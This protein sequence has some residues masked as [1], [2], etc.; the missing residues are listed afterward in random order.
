MPSNQKALQFSR[1]I[2]RLLKNNLLT[3]FDPRFHSNAH[4]VV[5][6]FTA[7]TPISVMPLKL[8]PR[9]VIP[10][11]VQVPSVSLAAFGSCTK[12]REEV[13]VAP[14]KM[15]LEGTTRGFPRD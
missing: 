15:T 7:N 10:P 4:A 1:W 9:K 3:L 6:G 8:D 13:E 2:F 5:E 14:L 11:H 12:S